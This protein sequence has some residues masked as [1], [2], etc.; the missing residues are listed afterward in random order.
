[1]AAISLQCSIC[2]VK[3]CAVMLG[4]V[5]VM[6]RL[7]TDMS[8]SDTAEEDVASEQPYGER[9]LRIFDVTLAAMLLLFI[10]PLL[11]VVALLIVCQDGGPVFFAHR[12][13]GRGGREFSC[14]K[15]RSML[16]DAEARLADLLESDPAARREWQQGHKLRSDP[17]ITAFGSFLRR[18]SLDELPQLINVL[19]GD[20]SLVGPRPI[21]HAEVKR[22]SH[23]IRH[24]HAVRP[25]ITGLWQVGGRSDV[26]YRRRVAF[27]VRYSQLRS[28]GLYLGILL[29]TVPSV[30]IRKGSY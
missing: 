4:S 23:R 8:G 26:S 12:R 1:M 7:E 10:L 5:V 14:L 19:R 24:Y 20:M 2:W 27:D 15:F 22:Y 3:R 11:L 21:V 25:G 13:V 28:P 30:L 18:S 9:L 29:R 6:D 16:V 17:R